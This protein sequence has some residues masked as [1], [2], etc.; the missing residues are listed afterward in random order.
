MIAIFQTDVACPI[1]AQ[2]LIKGLLDQYKGLKITIDF[3]DQDHILRVEGANFSI[4]DIIIFI[5]NEGSRCTHLPI[6][7]DGYPGFN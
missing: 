7:W 2:K 5:L 3:E 1:T 6:K 4:E